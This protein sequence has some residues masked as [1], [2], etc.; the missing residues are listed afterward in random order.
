MGECINRHEL[1]AAIVDTPSEAADKIAVTDIGTR[2]I[3]AMRQ[4]EI[5][6]IINKMPA[7]DVE[8]VKHGKWDGEGDGYAD[9]K[10]ILDVWYCS[11]CGHCID[12]GTDNRKML[13]KYCSNCGAKMDEETEE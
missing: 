9:G 12:D 4:N 6:S 2:A 13:P 5:I 1:I 7:E 8:P 3:L 10:I 11:E